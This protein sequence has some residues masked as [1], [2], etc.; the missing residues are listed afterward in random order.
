MSDV[1]QLQAPAPPAAASLS[2]DGTSARGDASK[3]TPA[4]QEGDGYCGGA[5]NERR[6][7][8][9][10]CGRDSGFEAVHGL[11]NR[12]METLGVPLAGAFLLLCC[13]R[14]L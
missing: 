2:S 11:L 5:K 6:L 9:I 4:T 7:V 12:V 1:V 10:H 13:P 14:V 3:T 8:A